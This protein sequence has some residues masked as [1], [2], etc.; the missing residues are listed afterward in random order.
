[1][2]AMDAMN[3]TRVGELQ[4]DGRITSANLAAYKA[5]HTEILGA[6]PEVSSITRYSVMESTRDER[7]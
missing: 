3:R 4:Q 6:V 1:M 5:L 7:A 2:S